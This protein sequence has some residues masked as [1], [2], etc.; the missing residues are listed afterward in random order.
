MADL[1]IDIPARRFPMNARRHTLT[2]AASLF[3]GL[4]PN[5]AL[6][7][8]RTPTGPGITTAQP[9]FYVQSYLGKCLDFGTAQ[10]SGT[11]VY[12]SDCNNSAEQQVLVQE[13]D[14]QHDVILHAGSKVLGLR[15]PQVL[16]LPNIGPSAPASPVFVLEL[17][18]EAKPNPVVFSNITPASQT[19]TLDGDSII[20]ASDHT[21]VVQ[22]QNSAGASG[23]PLMV[24]TRSLADAEFWDFNQVEGVDMD[25]TSGFVRAGYPGST[26]TAYDT[27]LS[28]IPPYQGNLCQ[29]ASPAC[30]PSLATP[31]TVIRIYP[32]TDIDLSG[33]EPLEIPSGVTIRGSR[34]GT[35]LGP[36]LHTE[37]P[38]G[39]TILEV[40]TGDADVRITGLRL[41][42]TSQ[43]TDENQAGSRGV[44]VDPLTLRTIID[45]NDLSSFT[46]AG[47]DVTGT[48]PA[49][50]PATACAPGDT[51]DP[52]NRPYD[53]FIARNFFHHNEMQNRGYGVGL[54]QGAFPLV[55][56]NMFYL[57]RHAIAGDGFAQTGYRAKFNLV[58]EDSPT[59]HDY[60]VPYYTQDFDM[61]GT[62]GNGFG[63][64]GGD[65]VQIY[66]NTFLGTNRPNFEIR[67]LPCSQADFN[68]NV[69]L[70]SPGDAV[71]VKFSDSLIG[72][73]GAPSS[74]VVETAGNYFSSSNPTNSLGVGDF[75]GDGVQDLFLA[76]GTA[77][78][79][80]PHGA[81][82]WRFL[83]A[84]TDRIGTLIFGDFDGDGRTDVATMDG[85][86]LKVSWGGVSDWEYLN[87]VNASI[88][89]L[90]VGKFGNHAPS[91]RRDDIF[92]AN[93]SEW[94]ISSGGSG[95][96]MISQT[97]SA[98][99]KDLRFGDFDGSGTT[100]VLG[101]IAGK[102]MVSYN[103]TSNWTPL[104][105]SLTGTMNG[106]VVADFD[107]DG[108]ADIATSTAV[109]VSFNGVLFVYWTW[110]FSSAGATDWTYRNP[111]SGTVWP[112]AIS[113]AAAIG[114]FDGNP[115]ADVL[116]WG[117]DE[118]L[119]IVPGGSLRGP[120]ILTMYSRE[121]LR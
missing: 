70:E 8:I 31:G 100:D 63:G 40:P 72:G 110:Q 20:L 10:T 54:A 66:S 47:V 53:A 121:D 7:Q 114:N 87:T 61:H 58:L 52:L 80:A 48:E 46:L 96:F 112:V 5:L 89:D 69:S 65:Y 97:S 88:N 51:S 34:R 104:P 64:R 12:V 57:N 24:A 116:I 73:E 13:V 85:N 71:S 16:P 82:D 77:W 1:K 75:D 11:Q 25:P 95:A 108:R 74:G 21:L 39:E 17:Q 56:G 33:L 68:G 78:Y 105:K 38:K 59:Q 102:W 67:G 79:Y 120:A 84:K 9:V 86:T 49:T 6:T 50:P 81:A 98:R 83:S 76:T 26:A 91:D 44:L 35:L 111:Q 93:G 115:G 119:Y 19:F 101:I 14:A 3:A 37:N 62:G 109:P 60:G 22:V 55:L 43:S 36:L 90:A 27:L 45:H 106:V 113:L 41:Q 30:Q 107:G 4:W 42:G 94:Y 99:V 117:N 103:S 23:S 18:V 29:N 92:W 15:P 118:H 28:R 32:G 2:V